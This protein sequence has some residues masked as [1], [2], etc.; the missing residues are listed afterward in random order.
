VSSTHLLEVDAKQTI[1]EIQASVFPG[2][3]KFVLRRLSP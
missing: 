1:R 2:G 3:P